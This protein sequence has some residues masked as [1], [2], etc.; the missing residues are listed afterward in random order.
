MVRSDSSLLPFE[1]QLADLVPSLA[2]LSRAGVGDAGIA[3][4]ELQQ[5]TDSKE[6]TICSLRLRQMGELVASCTGEAGGACGARCAASQCRLSHSCLAGGVALLWE[7][8]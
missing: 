1:G 5:C 6:T 3:G 7:R 8:V 4:N 2:C